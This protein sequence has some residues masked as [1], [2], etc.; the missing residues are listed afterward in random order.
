[1]KDQENSYY[2]NIWVV[3]YTEDVASRAY[4]GWNCKIINTQQATREIKAMSDFEKVSTI[5]EG[6]VNI[7]TQAQ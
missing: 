7:G 5:Y 3:N 4:H 1:M 2:S 6:M